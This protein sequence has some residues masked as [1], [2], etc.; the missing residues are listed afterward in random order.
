MVI[1][2]RFAWCHMQKTGG[3]ATLL[4]FELIPGLIVRADPRN[5]QAKHASFPEREAE[6]RGKLLVSNIRRLPAWTLSWN[7][8]H[9]QHGSVRAD[10]TPV[11]MESPQQMAELPRGDRR[12]AHFSGDG[13]FPIDR[14][15]RMEHLAEDFIA[16]ASELAD[17]TEEN[18]HD[19]AGHPQVNALDYDHEVGHWFTPG[20]VRLM[21]ES[22]PV[23]AALEERLYGDLDLLD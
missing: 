10:G 5:V 8:H 6:I 22:N 1:G 15:L 21:Y 7:Q 14:W 12:L 16:F 20:Q 4:F 13:R 2:E 11:L 18:R 9:Y 23:W 3:D 19:I 17:L